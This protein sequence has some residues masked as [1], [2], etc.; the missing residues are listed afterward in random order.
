M[1]RVNATALAIAGLLFCSVASAQVQRSFVASHGSDSNTATNCGFANPCRGFTAAQSVTNSGGEIVALDAAGYGAITITKSISIIANPG[2]YAG[3]S[4]STGNAV[5]IATAGVNVRLS[6]LRINGIGATNGV[7][8]TNGASLTIDNCTIS[9]FSNNGVEVTTAAKVRMVGSL[10]MNNGAAGLFVARG[11]VGSVSNSK[12]LGNQYGVW[13][14]EN[15]TAGTTTTIS[16]SNSIAAGN[17]HGFVAQADVAST[18]KIS[19]SNSSADD[20]ITAGIGAY[21][22]GG[23]VALAVFGS[24]KATHNGTGV[25]DYASGAALRSAG[26][27]L[28]NDNATNTLGTITNVGTM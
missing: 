12:F 9:G 18:A 4:A 19:V 21:Q 13:A 3:I 22:A 11:G 16:V 10:V 7:L 25:T 27:N 1:S 24:T 5:T 14:Y 6:G 26:N 17:T 20:N 8:M 23:G 2:F 15:V 28:V